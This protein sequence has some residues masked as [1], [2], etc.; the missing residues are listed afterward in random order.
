MT[1]VPIRI[2][3][4]GEGLE[5]ARL[6][7]F[8]KQSGESI[9]RDEP[10]FEM[11][12]D[13]AVSEVESPHAGTIVKWT[14]E[15]GALL[16]IGEEIGS[17][18]IKGEVNDLAVDPQ[19]IFPTND[20]HQ[21][22]N[23]VVKQAP[24]C[25]AAANV[26]IPPRTRR[27]LREKNL[28]DFAHQIPAAGKRL[29]EKDVD[30]Y[31]KQ[32]AEEVTRQP[33]SLSLVQGNTPE[34]FE[35]NT[36]ASTQ[37]TLNYR[38][39]RGAQ[40]VIPAILETDLDWSKIEACR[41]QT[42]TENGPTGFAMF[43][44]CVVQAMRKHDALRS[45]LSSDG[46]VKRTYRHVNLGVAVSLPGDELKAAVVRHADMMN[47]AAFFEELKKRIALAREGQDQIDETTT[48]SVSNIG[49]A[50]MRTGVPVVVSPAVATIALG[51]VRSEIVPRKDDF[52]FSKVVSLTM[53]FDHR[54]INGV[55]AA[56]F[57]CEVRDLVAQFSLENLSRTS[58]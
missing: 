13:K 10:L 36:L 17:L 56:N 35:E 9:E 25:T 26:P 3:Q 30:R 42:R 57:L 32:Q 39:A 58:R 23:T 4:L 8:F 21:P 18:E 46:K 43:L 53:S 31:L 38:M 51:E 7:R 33:T 12:T 14:V 24:L 2:P 55:G 49:A 37:Q 41:E 48:V 45:T 5:E 11:E 54:S 6:V 52:A 27:Y 50:K 22:V 47:Q 44:W 29:T 34:E 20:S 16:P 19:E 1:V 28:Q 15:E 40:L